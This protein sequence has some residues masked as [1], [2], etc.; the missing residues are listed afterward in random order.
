[1]T[2]NK[3]NELVKD[4]SNGQ[5]SIFLNEDHTL[6]LERVPEW[7]ENLTHIDSTSL[8]DLK[9]EFEDYYQVPA[10]DTFEEMLE[11]T[12]HY[13]YIVAS[14]TGDSYIFNPDC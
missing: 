1:M 7:T 14:I 4:W 11:Q 3:L 9:E 8:A 5:D 13:S 6:E 12:K 2:D 10:P